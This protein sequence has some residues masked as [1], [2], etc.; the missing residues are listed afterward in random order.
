MPDYAQSLMEPSQATKLTNAFVEEL[1]D[2]AGIHAMALLGIIK[3]AELA[4]T[5]P[6]PKPDSTLFVGHGDPNTA[7][8]FAYQRWPIRT[9]AARLAPDG[10][11][12]HALGQ[13][14]VVMVASKWNDQYRS[15]IADALGTPK[16]ELKDVALAD[17][18]RIR[19]DI[20]HHRGIA[21]K[22]NSGR[23]ELFRWFE[24]GQP[25]RVM[26]EHV[27]QLMAHMG[28][29]Q[30]TAEIEPQAA[31]EE[32]YEAGEEQ[33]EEDSARLA[34]ALLDAL[35]DV[36]GFLTTFIDDGEWEPAGPLEEL[37]VDTL[38]S[39]RRTYE[40]TIWM[41]RMAEP[42][43]AASLSES[44]FRSMLL[45]NWLVLHRS[46]PNWLLDRRSKYEDAVLLQYRDEQGVAVRGVDLSRLE[47]EEGH[48]RQMFGE[49]AEREWWM[50]DRDGAPLRIPEIVELLGAAEMFKPR[51]RGESPV[52]DHVHSAVAHMT[53]LPRPS[54]DAPGGPNAFRVL[55][56]SYW[57]FAQVIFAALELGA[58]GAIE[59]FEKLFIAGQAVFSE[60]LGMRSPWADKIAEWAEEPTDGTPSHHD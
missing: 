1:N 30:S 7:A 43:Q 12:V 6:S 42:E 26:P 14:W 19:N 5:F 32:R 15:L 53:S 59:H 23:C 28:T 34:P 9:L 54:Q 20:V 3:M 41:V 24:E 16:N 36:C 39:A 48:L 10:P 25:I 17:L 35:T 37:V 45:A 22:K 33:P 11:V 4:T 51:L 50:T 40:T 2:I 38:R 29:V 18:T 52:L 46:E 55:F 44:L 49:F 58:P 47:G 13:Q 21:T 27:A 8:G 31:W 57:A 56:T 60:A